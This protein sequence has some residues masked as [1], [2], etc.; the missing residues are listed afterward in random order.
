MTEYRYFVAQQREPAPPCGTENQTA[1]RHRYLLA[2]RTASC[3]AA[4]P[5]SRKWT[6]TFWELVPSGSVDDAAVDGDG[7][8]NLARC[9]LTELEGETGIRAS[10][11]AIPPKAVAFV[12][13]PKTRVTDVCLMLTVDWT[14]DQIRQR[15]AALENREYT[16]LEIIASGANP[17]VPAQI[18]GVVERS[19]R[20]TS[21][22]RRPAAL[23]WAGLPSTFSAT[24]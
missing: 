11:V 19:L 21:G 14:A 23:A 5:V 20:R 24:N 8:V 4:V 2:A 15:F 18:R 16:A 6:P 3:L 1:G 13:D 17:G 9:L 7:Q 10:E 12:E 22:H